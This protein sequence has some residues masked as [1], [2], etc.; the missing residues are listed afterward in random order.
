MFGSMVLTSLVL[1]THL[2]LGGWPSCLVTPGTGLAC[3]LFLISPVEVSWVLGERVGCIFKD[4]SWFLEANGAVGERHPVGTVAEAF[5]TF[6]FSFLLVGTACHLSRASQ[7]DNLCCLPPGLQ[8]LL[9]LSRKH[10]SCLPSVALNERKAPG[11]WK[12]DLVRFIDLNVRTLLQAVPLRKNLLSVRN[13]LAQ[14]P[15]SPRILS[16]L[17]NLPETPGSS[18]Q[19]WSGHQC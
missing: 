15:F 18:P 8:G 5:P 13:G 4:M 10:P 7:P 3:T 12:A 6:C 19:S 16:K 17:T 2:L 1:Q 11:V 9:Q 14:L